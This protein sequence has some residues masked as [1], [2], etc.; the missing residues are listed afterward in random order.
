MKPD[1]KLAAAIARAQVPCK[2]KRLS[3]RKEVIKNESRRD[4][5]STKG[6]RS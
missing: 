5:R 6:N 4:D 3:V 2:P 1:K